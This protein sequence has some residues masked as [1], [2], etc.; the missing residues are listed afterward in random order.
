MGGNMPRVSQ[1]YK[2]ES[3]TMDTIQV[4]PAGQ[5]EHFLLLGDVITIKA[6]G[7]GT[8]DRILVLENVVPSMT[9][10]FAS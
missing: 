3:E 8:S 9:M 5:G 2:G 6:A 7:Q 4:I 10:R 1:S